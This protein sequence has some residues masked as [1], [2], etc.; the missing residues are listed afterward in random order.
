MLSPSRN[1]KAAQDDIS[2]KKCFHLITSTVLVDYVWVQMRRVWGYPYRNQSHYLELIFFCYFC[3]V[4]NC[5]H[6]NMV[7]LSQS[8]THHSPNC[9]DFRYQDT[10]FLRGQFCTWPNKKNLHIYIMSN[11]I[12]LQSTTR[13]MHHLLL[14]TYP[15][16]WDDMLHNCPMVWLSRITTR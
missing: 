10:I 1:A 6:K 7:K 13:G 4:K 14:F 8:S 2:E 5:P 3:L 11:D 15:C 16:K 12:P 9:P